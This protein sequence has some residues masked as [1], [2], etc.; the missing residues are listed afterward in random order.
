MFNLT[1]D[2]SSVGSFATENM[3][4]LLLQIHKILNIKTTAGAVYLYLTQSCTIND[5]INNAI[6]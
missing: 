3:I 4:C 1:V 5:T 2:E 6:Y